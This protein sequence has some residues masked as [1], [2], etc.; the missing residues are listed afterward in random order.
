MTARIA[1]K[2]YTLAED[3]RGAADGLVNADNGVKFE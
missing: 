2:Y 3:A 1:S